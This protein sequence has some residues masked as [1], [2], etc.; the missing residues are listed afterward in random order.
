MS[1]FSL[2]W[3]H[4]FLS[5]PTIISI[6]NVIEMDV[7]GMMVAIT[8]YH[9]DIIRKKASL[10]GVVLN[11]IFLQLAPPQPSY[12]VHTHF[13]SSSNPYPRICVCIGPPSK[14]VGRAAH[15]RL[16]LAIK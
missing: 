4:R 9:F 6:S 7:C 1:S 5:H 2:C 15:F 13:N 12:R 16:H 14:Y 8:T 11:L 10:D 3:M